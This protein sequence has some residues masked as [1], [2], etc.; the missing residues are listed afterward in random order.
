M[1]LEL[2]ANHPALNLH[3]I[4][5]IAKPR[6]IVSKDISR[7]LVKRLGKVKI[8]HV[9]TLDPMAEGVLPILLG[10]ATRFQDHLLDN[11]KTYEFDVQFGFQ[12]DT[13]DSDGQ[14]TNRTTSV[15]D[16]A[17][18]VAQAL[19]S[20]VGKISQIPPIYS[21]IKY[22][23]KPLYNYAR[24]GNE[25]VVP[26]ANL[27]RNVEVSKLELIRFANQTATILVS[28]SKGLYVRCLAR[29]IAF[30]LGTLGTV[31]RLVRTEAAGFNLKDCFYPDLGQNQQDSPSII[32]QVIPLEKAPLNLP[33]L[34]ITE[35]NAISRLLMGQDLVLEKNLFFLKLMHGRGTYEPL[36]DDILVFKNN[37]GKLFGIGTVISSDTG[38]IKIRMKRQLK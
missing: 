17:H 14:V 21:A 27:E 10:S 22:N 16:A 24:Q 1:G 29:D 18:Q 37:L 11:S 3:G 25:E 35:A 13:L 31:T 5:P 15:P 23:G 26:L 34:E 38:S 7:W 33:S 4:L 19:P 30:S 28:G 8:G 9:G 36:S 6:G 12:T 32:S 2:L 20:F